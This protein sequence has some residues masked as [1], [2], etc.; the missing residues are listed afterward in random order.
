MHG[1]CSVWAN[2]LV[3]PINQPS[4]NGSNAQ[5]KETDRCLKFFLFLF[6]VLPC[7]F[8]HFPKPLFLL[9]LSSLQPP[10]SFLNLWLRRACPFPRQLSLGII[11]DPG[12][13]LVLCTQFSWLWCTYRML[14]HDQTPLWI[15]HHF[16]NFLTMF[17]PFVVNTVAFLCC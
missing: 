5:A 14:F 17:Q 16:L 1:S 13:G 11:P 7:E 3:T 12:C 2:F 15:G 4:T 8:T 9:L 10:L 6:Y